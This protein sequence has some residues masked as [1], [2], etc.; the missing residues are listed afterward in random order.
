MDE[1]QDNNL[2]KI[3]QNISD[4]DSNTE[5][6]DELE[7][8]EVNTLNDIISEEDELDE[9]D[10]LASETFNDNYNADL[11]S[12]AGV[13]WYKINE[14]EKTR[15]RNRIDFSNHHGPTTFAKRN[16]DESALSAFSLIVSNTMIKKIVNYTNIYS[17]KE[18]SEFELDK[19]DL[20]S[21]IA[22]LLCRGV[23]CQKVSVNE[24]WSTKY[25]K[26]IVSRMMSRNKFKHIMKYLRLDDKNTRS[27]RVSTDKFCMVRE[28]W[29]LFISNS[30]SAYK[31]N[32]HLTVDEQLLPCKSRCSFI[33]Y[34]PNKPDKFGLKFWLLVEL[35]NKYVLNGYPYL[36]KSES[37]TDDLLCEAVVKNLMKPYFGFGH[38]ISTDN[39]FTT[40]NLAV[41]LLTKKTTIIGTIRKNKRELP[42]CVR[43]NQRLHN[44]IFFEN[45]LGVLLTIYQGRKDKNVV[46]LSTFHDGPIIDN[47][48]ASLKQKPNIVL[49]YN[50]TKC[51]VDLV[52]QMAR[53][54]SV[55]APTRRWPI[56][57]F[58][59]IINFSIINS[60][61]IYKQVN[62]SNITRRNFIIKIIEEIFEINQEN[63]NFSSKKISKNKVSKIDKTRKD[64]IAYLPSNSERTPKSVSVFCQAKINCH[65]NRSIN[66]CSLCEKAICGSC[67]KHKTIISTCSNCK[68]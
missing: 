38:C 36:G 49:D 43:V 23:F 29:E 41:Y 2:L 66:I 47:E 65:K 21:F 59:N 51:G 35:D 5:S 67:T 27:N 28:I 8:D 13:T 34:M 63:K 60:W 53:F 26:P 30:Q 48:E 33:Q 11:T 9:I 44:S 52:D 64:C 56:Q 20:L 24:M 25:G 57:V 46:L 16:V 40:Y 3:L 22:I 12:K 4:D 1:I 19:I 55:K 18:R 17:K 45:N 32:K 39:Y 62:N 37:S 42:S 15:V 31:P 58:Y 10:E 6:N 61:I 54:Y 50:E 68:V 14:G 7:F